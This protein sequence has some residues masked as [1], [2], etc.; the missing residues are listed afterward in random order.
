M[1]RKKKK[2]ET[3]QKEKVLK[4]CEEPKANT[5]KS[6]WQAANLEASVMVIPVITAT[7]VL[8]A[9]CQAGKH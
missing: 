7:A 4:V 9:V 2:S 5:G 3:K 6:L 8:C 1:D